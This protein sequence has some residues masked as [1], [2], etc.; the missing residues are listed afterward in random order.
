MPDYI[1][2]KETDKLVWLFAFGNWLTEDGGVHALAHGITVDQAVDYYLAVVQTSQAIMDA[3]EKQALARAATAHKHAAI[4]Q[5]VATARDYAQKLQHDPTMTDADRAAAG[6]TV[7][8][9]TQ[10]AASADAVAALEP[11]LLL[12]DFH[13]RHQVTIHWGPNPG[14]EHQNAKP[15]G[16]MG[17]EIQYARG[18]LPQEES[19][20][21]SLG[22]DTDSPL[23]HHIESGTSGTGNG[24]PH[25]IETGGKQGQTRTRASFG[26]V[27][28]FLY[29][30]RYVDKKLR[31]GN[32]GDPVECTV[33]V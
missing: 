8:D 2:S 4:G 6:I 27:P 29:R 33:N 19:G 17:C 32:F 30:A 14:N 10:T 12:L 15:H 9:A 16:V 28:V 24:V 20:W 21:T 7:P 23:L 25:P 13:L 3:T 1:P 31:Y 5:A 18:A 22:L 11:P 26:S